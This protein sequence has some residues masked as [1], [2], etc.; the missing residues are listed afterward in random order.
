MLRTRFPASLLSEDEDLVLDGAPH[1]ITLLK[2]A[3]QTIGIVA[4]T[5][6]LWLWVPFRWG[7]W[8]YVIVTIVALGLLFFWPAR[9]VIAWL[10]T[11]FVVTTDR[12][13]LRSGWIAK[14]S[15]EIRMEKISDVRFSQRV[16][17]RIMGVGDLFIE[18]AGREGHSIFNN[19]A[20]PEA[21]QRV[22]S[23]M[24]ERNESKK[25]VVHVPE[26]GPT[27]PSIADE[28]IK[29]HQLR[30]EGALTDDE[31]QSVKEQ[32]LRRASG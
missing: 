17:E 20:K 28:L 6:L 13:I 27:M 14:R 21:V 10:T 9:D 2:P 32:L 31:F 22:I 19:V 18:S 4:A 11:H 23:T 29:L 25:T 24:R 26:M 16:L 12:V 15:M 8:P 3:A 7:S 5:L 1:W 30:G